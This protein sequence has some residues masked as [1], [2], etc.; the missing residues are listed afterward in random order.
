MAAAI[1]VDDALIAVGLIAQ[2]CGG[3]AAIH[4]LQVHR[5]P[6]MGLQQRLGH[7]HPQDVF[8]AVILP[9]DRLIDLRKAQAG[10]RRRPLG[11][12]QLQ[13]VEQ[14]GRDAGLKLAIAFLDN[15]RFFRQVPAIHRERAAILSG[16]Q[17]IT[18]LIFL[19]INLRGAVQMGAVKTKRLCRPC[20]LPGK[21]QH[22][23][24]L[25][26]P[27]FHNNVLTEDNYDS[28]PRRNH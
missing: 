12:L 24:K 8:P 3:H 19:E 20:L 22:Q 28:L 11:I 25:D 17:R 27:E 23:P 4:L 7:I 18:V 13:G 26:L 6:I 10:G 16:V 15:T 14:R 2:H 5:P 21:E 9:A 1:P